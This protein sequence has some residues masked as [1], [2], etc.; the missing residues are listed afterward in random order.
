VHYAVVLLAMSM[1]TGCATYTQLVGI[2]NKVEPLEKKV[3]NY[4]VKGDEFKI[5]ERERRGADEVALVAIQRRNLTR[6]ELRALA[7]H[8]AAEAERPYVELLASTDAF[9]ACIKT[10]WAAPP[11]GPDPADAEECER[12]TV[13]S[14]ASPGPR[15]LYWGA[16]APT[17]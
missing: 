11:Q 15:I 6:T 2:R 9:A 5:V 4:V 14:V 1:I 13:L 16:A 3:T 12:G 17:Y 7:R 8:L 10:R